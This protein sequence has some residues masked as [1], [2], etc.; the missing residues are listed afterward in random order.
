MNGRK[1]IWVVAGYVVAY[2]AAQAA[3]YV[4]IQHTMGPEAQASA[5]MYAFGDAAL[6]VMVFV[7]LALIPT[8][9]AL[10]WLRRNE[11]FWVALAILCLAVAA[12]GPICLALAAGIPA[13]NPAPRS[14]LVGMEA[15]G[16]LRLIGTPLFAAVVLACM[17]M[18]PPG[19]ARRMM[20]VATWIEAGTLAYWLLALFVRHRLL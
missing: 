7:G 4:R 15:F 3:V 17:V 14:W 11:R 13:L 16:S 8:V 18:T 20:F 10:W 6:G 5:G 2:M 12:T 9:L 19:R 1:W